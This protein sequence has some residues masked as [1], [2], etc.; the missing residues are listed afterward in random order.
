[1][2]NRMVMRRQPAGVVSRGD[3]V[4]GRPLAIARECTCD[5]KDKDKD[6]P[7]PDSEEERFSFS[8]CMWGGD[9]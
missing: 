6:K 1:M 4:R 5:D 2:R 7:P 9:C 3:A 8:D